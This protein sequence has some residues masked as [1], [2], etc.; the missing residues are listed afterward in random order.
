M[1]KEWLLINTAEALHDVCEQLLGSEWLSVDTEF[2][3][4]NTYFPELCLLQIANK[5]VTAIVDPIA[6][7]DLS[8]L[9]NILYDKT[10][11]KVF[12]AARQDLELFYLLQDDLP[13]PVFD[14]QV[15]ANALGLGDQIGY[16]NLIRDVLNIE[17]AKSETRTNWKRRPLTDKQLDYAADDV[18]YL[19]EVYDVLLTELDKQNKLAS[20]DSA[21]QALV[22]VET[23]K[24]K[25]EEMWKK[26]K[27]REARKLSGENLEALKQLAAWRELTAIKK[28][29][30]R[31]WILENHTILEL[32]MQLPQE[33]ADLRNIKGLNKKVE[34]KYGEELLVIMQ[35]L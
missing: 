1:N 17:L 28:N 19:G 6:I 13:A 8:V 22:N 3:R 34:E 11:T 18:I 23:Y 27:S 35:G 33:L 15:A 31:K 5:D 21:L 2:E 29:K 25:P 26:F 24:P 7:D 32:A 14:T 30:P 12:H 9:Y 16:A 20:L 10:I 4:T